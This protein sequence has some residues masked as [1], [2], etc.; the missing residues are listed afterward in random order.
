MKDE[1]ESGFPRKLKL[2]LV[3]GVVRTVLAPVHSAHSNC[4]L[5]AQKTSGDIL[6][7]KGTR[8]VEREGRKRRREQEGRKEGREETQLRRVERNTGWGGQQQS[9]KVRVRLR[10]RLRL[11]LRFRVR[12]MRLGQDKNFVPFHAVLK[13]GKGGFGEGS[14]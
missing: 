2:D 12:M 6:A 7:R 14:G 13:P 10:L 1:D 9:I 4:I 3:W 11:R 5:C 8:G